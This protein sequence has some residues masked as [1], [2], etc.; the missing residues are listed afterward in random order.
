MYL[1]PASIPA[2]RSTRSSIPMPPTRPPSSTQTTIYSGC[3]AVSTPQAWPTPTFR[4]RMAMLASSL[5]RMGSRPTLPLVASRS[6]RLI[7]VTS[8]STI[9]GRSRYLTSARSTATFPA[10]ATLA[11]PSS[12]PKASSSPSCIPACQGACPTTSRSE[13]RVTTS[14][15]SS[16]NATLTPISSASSS[17]PE[18]SKSFLLSSPLSHCLFSSS[19]CIPWS[20][21]PDACCFLG[22]RC[23]RSSLVLFFFE[24]CS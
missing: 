11:P 8:S 18:V 17:T 7:R 14:S 24:W 3:R 23:E 5:P 22:I 6:W 12:T 1:Q 9:L 19:P 15:S 16:R 10:K 21:A 2:T 13:L 4:T 20:L